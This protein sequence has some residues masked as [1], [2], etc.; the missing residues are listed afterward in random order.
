[1]VVVVMGVVFSVFLVLDEFL[2]MVELWWCGWMNFLEREEKRAEVEYESGKNVALLWLLLGGI[3]WGKG[4]VTNIAVKD[5]NE[6]KTT[7]P[8]KR[9]ER[10]WK[11]AKD[12]SRRHIYL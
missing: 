10:A 8:G 3:T 4:E 1:V 12:R 11:R 2:V 6:A 7:K 5:K 9:L